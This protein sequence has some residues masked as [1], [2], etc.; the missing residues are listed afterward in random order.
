LKKTIL[1]L[2][3]DRKQVTLFQLLYL[4]LGHKQEL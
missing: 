2:R 4:I 3:N 1:V